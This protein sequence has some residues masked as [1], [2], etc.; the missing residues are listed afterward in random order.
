MGRQQRGGIRWN[1][2][3]AALFALVAARV[4]QAVSVL[5][6]RN[7]PVV[8]AELFRMGGGGRF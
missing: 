7:R 5:P 6:F 1:E 3:A 2:F 8:Y 4:W